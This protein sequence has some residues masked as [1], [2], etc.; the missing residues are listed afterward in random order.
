MLYGPLWR[1]LPGPRWAKALQTLALALVVVVVCFLWVF[2]AIAPHMPFNDNTVDGSVPTPTTSSSSTSSSSTTTTS[3][4][5]T[6]TTSSSTTTT[7]S[8]TT[9]LPSTQDLGQRPTLQERA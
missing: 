4:S 9:S 2:P 1:V 5:T 6:T 3:S 7:T 8:T